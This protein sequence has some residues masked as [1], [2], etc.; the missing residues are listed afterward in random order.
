MLVADQA[1]LRWLFNL[2]YLVHIQRFFQHMNWR[3]GL[4]PVPM[5]GEA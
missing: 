4:L 3:T 5:R 1:V 2:K